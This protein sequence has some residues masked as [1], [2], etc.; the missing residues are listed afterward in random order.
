MP[1]EPDEHEELK[2]RFDYNDATDDGKIEFDEFV[3]MLKG[4]DAFGVPDEARVGF[5]TV[6]GDGAGMIDIDEFIAR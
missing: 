2:E 5:D 3:S 6:D 4:H 1:L